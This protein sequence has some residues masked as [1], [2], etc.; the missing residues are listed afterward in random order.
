MLHL[1]PVP[2]QGLLEKLE[3]TD[4]RDVSDELHLEAAQRL[5]NLFGRFA[6][7]STGDERSAF[8]EAQYGA[9]CVVYHF[10]P[11]P[12]SEIDRIRNN[13]DVRRKIAFEEVV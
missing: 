4:L 8:N 6:E 10:T 11:E 7:A 3:S 2:Q 1:H 13:N 12:P 5:S 9:E